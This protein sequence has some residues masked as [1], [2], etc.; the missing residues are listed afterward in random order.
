MKIS[1][2]STL[3]LNW[4]DSN[5]WQS[6]ETVNYNQKLDLSEGEPLFKLFSEEE[7]F[8]HTQAIS[9]RKY[10]MKKRVLGFLEEL[11]NKGESGQVIILAAGLAPL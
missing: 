5:L 2:T 7:T 10:F 3:V 8:M 9:G 11:R 6:R 1:A 4:T